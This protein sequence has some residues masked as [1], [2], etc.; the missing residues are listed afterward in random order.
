M[1]INEIKGRIVAKGLTQEEFAKLLGISARTLT[2]RFKKGFFGS[3]EMTKMIEILDIKNPS[4]IFFNI[5][6]T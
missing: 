4:E 3:D 5:K 6:V 1:N 2:S